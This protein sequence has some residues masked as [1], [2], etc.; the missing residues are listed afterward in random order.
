MTDPDEWHR[1]DD[2]D[3]TKVKTEDILALRGG[4]DWHMAYYLIYRHLVT[5]L[6]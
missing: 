1:F 4:G 3:V 5:D 2:D 6:K